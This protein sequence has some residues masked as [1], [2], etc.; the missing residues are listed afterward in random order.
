MDK[1]ELAGL[2]R[3]YA[4]CLEPAKK[5][6]LRHSLVM[7]GVDPDAVETVARPSVTP[8]GRSTRPLVT[9]EAPKPVTVAPVVVEAKAE[10]AEKPATPKRPSRPRTRKAAEDTK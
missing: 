7:A 8:S 3:K 6:E 9:A 2:K 10:V 5:A 4:A 1:R